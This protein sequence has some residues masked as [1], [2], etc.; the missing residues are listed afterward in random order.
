MRAAACDS[1]WDC[2]A[3]RRLQLPAIGLLTGGFGAA[4]LRDAGAI[5]VHETLAELAAALAEPADLP[6]RRPQD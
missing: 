3:A 5:A 4:E 1:T 2:Q 6:L